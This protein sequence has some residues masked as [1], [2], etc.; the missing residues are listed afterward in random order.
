M[1]KKWLSIVAFCIHTAILAVISV[2]WT[3][4]RAGLAAAQRPHWEFN[5]PSI[6]A[7]WLKKCCQLHFKTSPAAANRLPR[8]IIWACYIWPYYS[9]DEKAFSC[10][11][12]PVNILPCSVCCICRSKADTNIPKLLVSKHV[13]SGGPNSN[14]FHKGGVLDY[15]ANQ[16]IWEYWGKTDT[17]A[18]QQVQGKEQ[19]KIEVGTADVQC[20]EKWDFLYSWAA[21]SM[22]DGTSG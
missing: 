17:S 8:W 4:Y 19:R 13:Y 20:N 15:D 6:A 10:L 18:R 22:C 2:P 7:F 16:N 9:S 14:I 1:G 21:V 3:V 12:S 11:Q 5:V